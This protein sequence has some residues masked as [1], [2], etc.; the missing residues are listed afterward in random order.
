MAKKAK[1]DILE[2]TIEE[3]SE[4][5]LRDDITLEESENKESDEIKAGSDILIKMKRW[6][7][8][9]LFWIILI[10]VVMLGLIAGI[11]ISLNEGMDERRPVEQ[12]K[13]TISGIPVHAEGKMT[14]F[15]GFVVDQK[16]EKGNIWIVFCDV[17]LELDKPETAKSVDSDRVDVR[18]IIYIILKQETVKEGLSPE[19]KTRLK[20]RL[21]NELNKL[22]GDNLVKNIYF[23]RYEMN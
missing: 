19:G 17:A 10:S 3:K 7:L 23:T 14:F 13:Q 8:K 1:L 4:D 11:L 21:K 2:I 12:K 6:M 5:K 9:P 18:N 22:L 16:D 15:E 20:E